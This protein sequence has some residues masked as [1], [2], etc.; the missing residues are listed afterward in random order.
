MVAVDC[1]SGVD[2]DSG[3]CAPEVIPATI[4]VCM[5]AVKQG[6]LSFPA[7][8]KAGRLTVVSIGLPE[9]LKS[10]DKTGPCGGHTNRSRASY[11]S[12]PDDCA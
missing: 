6:L 7:Y 9:G 10:W 3:E 2:C 8:E 4:T 12:P 1:P 5:A 11:P